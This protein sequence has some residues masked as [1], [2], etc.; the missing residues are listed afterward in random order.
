MDSHDVLSALRQEDI[1]VLHVVRTTATPSGRDLV[2]VYLESTY[3]Q[4]EQASACLS[5]LPG[6]AEVT[7]ARH[8]KAIMYV[9]LAP[10]PGR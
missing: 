5:R 1:A 8:T 2:V 6:I 9:F 3:G 4:A 10:A 7:F